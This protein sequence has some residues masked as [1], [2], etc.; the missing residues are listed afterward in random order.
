MD[1]TNVKFANTGP[2]F[3]IKVVIFF[4]EI[5]RGQQVWLVH[6]VENIL[7]EKTCY[8]VS[9]ILTQY[10]IQNFQIMN[11]LIS[12]KSPIKGSV[13]SIVELPGGIELIYILDS[14]PKV[15]KMNL[16]WYYIS[17]VEF[18]IGLEKY[19][20]FVIMSTFFLHLKKN[21]VL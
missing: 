12:A 1:K 11:Q 2:N 4:Q 8:F 13:P 9:L 19:S 16:F 18:G 5:C 6:K 17:F 7:C 14:Y 21:F 15:H 10:Q 3:D 20:K